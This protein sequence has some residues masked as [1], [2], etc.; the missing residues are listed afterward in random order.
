MIITAKGCWDSAKPQHNLYFD[1]QVTANLQGAKKAL[2][3]GVYDF[4]RANHAQIRDGNETDFR[5]LQKQFLSITAKLTP[6]TKKRIATRL[7][8]IYNYAS[9]S[10]KH[11][12]N[13]CAYKLCEHLTVL[14]CPYCNLSYGHTLHVGTG[15][16]IRPTL[17]HY[18]DKAKYPLFAISLGNLVAS[19]YHCN[20]SLKGAKDFYL[21]KHLNPLC[22]NEQIVIKLDVDPLVARYDITTFDKANI[23]LEINSADSRAKNSIKTFCLM[24]RYQ[25]LIDEARFIAKNMEL[26]SVS[27]TRSSAHL[28]WIRRGVTSSNYKD[29]V[30]G[31]L[32]VDFS[33]FYLR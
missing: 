12:T 1:T 6:A 10:R 19:C 24:E 16:K 3:V 4:L 20:S 8:S 23:K 13:W 26:Y 32:I 9:F 11:A 31:K 14:T 27:T 15:G 5:L 29:R 21:N 22:N 30:L 33:Q 18:L 7:K 17:D 28:E 2:T 25:L